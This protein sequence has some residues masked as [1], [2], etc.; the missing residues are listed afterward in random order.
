[1]REGRKA[2]PSRSSGN[3]TSG[4]YT[5]TITH[6][7]A[8]PFTLIL[9][10]TAA[11]KTAP[12][13]LTFQNFACR[14]PGLIDSNVRIGAGPCVRIHNR[15]LPEGLPADHPGFVLLF[16]SGSNSVFGVYA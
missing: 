11:A 5:Q 8:K 6:L 15:N 14:T 12:P 3:P 7:A 13:S 9:L 2:R 16:H 4:V 1:W 10:K